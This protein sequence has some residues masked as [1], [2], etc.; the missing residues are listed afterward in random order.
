[1]FFHCGA[2]E[3]GGK[4]WIPIELGERFDNFICHTYTFA[5]DMLAQ[6]SYDFSIHALELQE[7]RESDG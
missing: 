3:K 1:M 4:V 6:F 2:A 5:L 7:S